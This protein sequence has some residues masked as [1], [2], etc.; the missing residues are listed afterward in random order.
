MLAVNPLAPVAVVI[1]IGYVPAEAL[2]PVVDATVA[3]LAPVTVCP[4]NNPTAEAT[5]NEPNGCVN[6]EAWSFALTVK[7]AGVI[8]AGAVNVAP[9]IE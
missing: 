5:D 8:F 7:G 4:P 6:K 2:A 3:K 9:A 1:V